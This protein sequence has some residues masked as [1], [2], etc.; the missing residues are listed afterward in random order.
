[1]AVHLVCAPRTAA[2]LAVH[3]H[4]TQPLID[5]AEGWILLPSAPVDSAP[6][7]YHDAKSGAFVSFD[8]TSR[9]GTDHARGDFRGHAGVLRGVPYRIEEIRDVRNYL[10][11]Q[12]RRRFGSDY[13]ERIPGAEDF[14]PLPD[15]TRL[16][17]TFSAPSVEWR[18]SSDV[19]SGDQEDR[20]RQLLLADSAVCV[21]LP[22]FERK[23][24]IDRAAYLQL[25][26]GDSVQQ[27]LKRLGLPYLSRPSGRAGFALRYDLQDPDRNVQ[28]DLHF[29]QQQKL[30]KKTTA[31]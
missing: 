1:M 14:L 24:S 6:G 5:V 16:V 2:V 11:E 3:P 28:V 17:V 13:P 7:A 29:S 4:C 9:S 8:G 21:E 23:A 20:V 31:E 27:V 19:Y 12:R 18:F 25:S 26:S 10:I 30:V 22:A 15:A